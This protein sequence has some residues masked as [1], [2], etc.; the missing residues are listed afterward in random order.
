MAE[1]IVQEES[2]TTVADA[3]RA[4]GGTTDALSFPTGFADAISAIKAGGGGGDIDALI[5]GSITEI[6]SNVT[7]VKDYTFYECESLV[8]AN[9]GN[10][11]SIGDYGFYR[12]HKLTTINAP[13]TTSIGTQAFRGCSALST[14]DFP[15][16]TKIGGNAFRDCTNLVSVTLPLV[17]AIET[18][19]FS[20]C[21]KL[22]KCD[23]PVATSIAGY[24][25]Q[26][27]YCLTT[28]ILRSETMCTL[29]NKNAFGSC[30][31]ILGLK[32]YTYNPDGLEDGYFYVPRALVESYQTASGWS[33]FATQ[34]RALEDYTVDGTITGEL[35]E[36]KI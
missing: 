20:E 14:I 9:F 5:D 18:Y 36:N 2:L 30:N 19:A 28:V 13:N 1:R 12:C 4:K 33:S 3:I 7:S 6:T 31:H 23:F 24:A 10:A 27:C 25:L 34:F 26:F 8:T 29:S 16:T 32:D 22:I 15:K 17:T 11:T 21:T 35:D